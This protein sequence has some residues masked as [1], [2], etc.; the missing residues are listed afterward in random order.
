MDQ[1]LRCSRRVAAWLFRSDLKDE[2]TISGPAPQ[3]TNRLAKLT[4]DSLL[5]CAPNTVNLLVS[6]CEFVNGHDL[7]LA[8]TEIEFRSCWLDNINDDVFFIG[9]AAQEI[10]IHH[11][12]IE[13]V[14]T[15]LNLIKHESADGS[16][17]FYRNLVELRRLTIGR[18][19]HPHPE[20]IDQLRAEEH[21]DD[22]DDDKR[23]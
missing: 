3:E 15:C 23:V 4:I 13:R 10:R 22:N 9:D 6:N 2:Y 5:R 17:Y 11:N 16:V 7:Q 8:G 20:I 18:R 12:V 19:P 1:R 14:L 21:G